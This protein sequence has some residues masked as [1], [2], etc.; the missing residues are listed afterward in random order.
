MEHNEAYFG[1]GHG[2]TPEVNLMEKDV[3]YDGILESTAGTK[4][5]FCPF[6]GE[7]IEI[8][9]GK[10]TTYQKKFRQHEEPRRWTTCS[11]EAM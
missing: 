2:N 8:V 1:F 11:W 5:N 4:I 9:E 6:C 10:T 7:A 3:D